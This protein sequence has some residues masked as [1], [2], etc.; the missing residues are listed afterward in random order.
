MSVGPEQMVVHY[1]LLQKLGEGGMGVVWKAEDT[2]LGRFVAL[3]FVPESATED[4]KRVER[5][6]RE[7]RTASA[8]NHNNICTTYDI[9]EW[10]QRRY[11]AMELLDGPTLRQ[12]IGGHSQ[13]RSDRAHRIEP[14]RP[15]G[16]RGH[17]QQGAREGPRFALP[18]RGRSAPVA[19]RLH[20]VG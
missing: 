9:G 1:R 19:A 15:A 4:E 18:D 20:D 3:K 7:A 17:H 14:T 6:L 2:R 12:R 16:T 8:L 13:A 10:E 5:F 11:I